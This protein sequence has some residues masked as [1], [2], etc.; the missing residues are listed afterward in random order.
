MRGM[1]DDNRKH[2]VRLILGPTKHAQS[3]ASL[4]QSRGVDKLLQAAD[5]EYCGVVASILLSKM[6]VSKD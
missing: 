5:P 1:K 4:R 6:R 2:E 3:W